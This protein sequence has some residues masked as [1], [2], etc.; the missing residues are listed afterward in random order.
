MSSLFSI[1]LLRF[2]TFGN[3]NNNIGVFL[4]CTSSPIIESSS[5]IGFGCFQYGYND[6]PMHL[7][8]SSLNI[9]NNK[10]YDIFDFTPEE[11]GRSNNHFHFFPFRPYHYQKIIRDTYPADSENLA[12]LIDKGYLLDFGDHKNH[13]IPLSCE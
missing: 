12:M 6:F 10:W 2:F 5:D 4:F 8:K 7:F 1:Y 3:C 13:C 11:R 9:W